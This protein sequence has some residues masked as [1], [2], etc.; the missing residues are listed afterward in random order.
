M[1]HV[2][3]SSGR[4]EKYCGQILDFLKA[5]I[6]QFNIEGD[7]VRGFRSPDSPALWIRDHS[8]ILRGGQYIETEV[9][10]AI[11]CFANMQAGNGRIFDY[12]LTEPLRHSNERENWEKWV[13]IAVEADVEFR[14]VK[15]A[16]L[17]WQA[18]GDDDWLAA[19]LPACDRALTYT[20][21]HPW[22]WDA[23]H[24]LVKRPYTIDTWDF[25][26][27]AGRTPWLNFQITD[28]TY[29][30]IFHGDNSGTY[31]AAQLLRRMH[32]ALGQSDEAARWRRQRNRKEIRAGPAPSGART[33]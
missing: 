6:V 8:D 29:W 13:R 17:S 26:Y 32:H 4:W 10:S 2:K 14:F 12:V 22:R 20:V 18:S 31:E 19:L 27:T 23:N 24:Q 5:D 28:Q 15:A 7:L 33:L 1:L 21:T 25:D 16:Y 3:T 30:G 11:D 9:T